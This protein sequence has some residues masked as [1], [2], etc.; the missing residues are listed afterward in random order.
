MLG[1]SA[2]CSHNLGRVERQFSSLVATLGKFSHNDIQ[3]DAEIR[4]TELVTATVPQMMAQGK[5]CSSLFS[6]LRKISRYS[7][8][9]CLN[10]CI[11]CPYV[12][13]VGGTQ[14]INPEIA[15]SFS[16]GGFSRLFPAPTYQ[17]KAVS[18]YLESLGTK[19]EGLYKY[20][21]VLGHHPP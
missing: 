6:Q 8:Y 17:T 7:A 12:T 5:L 18:E 11:S 1:E 20:A 14:Q 21:I 2:I 4:P 10:F 16:G 9:I 19:Y 13:A 3:K 15:V